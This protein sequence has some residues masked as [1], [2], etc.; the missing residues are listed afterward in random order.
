MLG[1]SGITLQIHKFAVGKNTS[2]IWFCNDIDEQWKIEI[3]IK[4]CSLWERKEEENHRSDHIRKETF[5]SVC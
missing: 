3:G 2:C 1:V 4:N 5:K